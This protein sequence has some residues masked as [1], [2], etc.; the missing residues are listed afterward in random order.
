ML[1]FIADTMY[2]AFIIAPLLP[3]LRDTQAVFEF[4]LRC[5]YLRASDMTQTFPPSEHFQ[6]H[7]E[8][9][10]ANFIQTTFSSL[11]GPGSMPAPT[12]HSRQLTLPIAQ[13]GFGL[14]YLHAHINGKHWPILRPRN[15]KTFAVADPARSISRT[16]Y[17]AHLGATR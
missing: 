15:P 10:S 5:L 9:G 2:H 4:L 14:T 16:G 1:F 17:S 7:L 8:L 6:L 11:L 12:S 3:K 13:G